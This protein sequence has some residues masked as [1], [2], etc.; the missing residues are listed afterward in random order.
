[1]KRKPRIVFFAPHFAEYSTRLVEALTPYADV[2]FVVDR[3]SRLRE[4]SP[5]WFRAA[6]VGV[7]VMEFDVMPRSALWLW[8]PL[9]LARCLLFGPD[10]MHLHEQIDPLTALLAYLKP[11]RTRLALTVHDP[12]PHLGRDADVN[13]NGRPRRRM[14]MVR[15]KAAL[16]HVH[17]DYCRRELVEQLGDARPIAST[18]HGFILEPA[19]EEER[20]SEPGRILF[21]GRMEQYKG[22]DVLIDAFERLNAR[23]R[24]YSLVLAGPGPAVDAERARRTRGVTLVNRFIAPHEAIAEFQRA[25]LVALPYLEA[26]QSGVAAAAIGNGRAMVSS[27]V[28]GLVDVIRDGDNGLLV[29]PAD[30]EKL[31]DAIDRILQDPALL[32]KI[33]AGS[34]RSREE[35]SWMRVAR[36]LSE[37]YSAVLHRGTDRQGSRPGPESPAPCEA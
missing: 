10:L 28:G 32:E 2:L 29:P 17:G 3:K 27:A 9:V 30:P 22:A 37:T 18:H 31:A 25:S 6:T 33:T 7:R 13:E 26:T 5:G 12:K 14:D 36:T 1:M 15:S 8:A 19:P 11:R 4:C 34:R 35:L 24:D 23:G 16:F 21:F 20:E